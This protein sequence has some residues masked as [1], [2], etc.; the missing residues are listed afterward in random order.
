MVRFKSSLSFPKT[1][2]GFSEMEC[3]NLTKVLP[4]VDFLFH[5]GNPEGLEEMM[6]LIPTHPHFLS[7]INHDE[8]RAF[9]L[10]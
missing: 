8:L 5:E 6:S 4:E 3:E 7:G 2:N 1:R 10:G 9:K